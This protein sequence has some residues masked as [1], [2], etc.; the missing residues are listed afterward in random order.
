MPR[1]PVFFR[2]VSRLFFGIWPD[3]G[4]VG[5]ASWWP[6]GGNVRSAIAVVARL[7][8]VCFVE[9]GGH[10]AM[11]LALAGG[12]ALDG[13]AGKARPVVLE[14][15]AVGHVRGRAA[16]HVAS[17]RA[18]RIAGAPAVLALVLSTLLAEPPVAERVVAAGAQAARDVAQAHRER[19][20]FLPAAPELGRAERV[21][22]GV[23]ADLLVRVAADARLLARLPA[24]VPAASVVRRALV[25]AV[26]LQAVQR[27]DARIVGGAHAAFAGGP[28]I[29]VRVDA[30]LVDVPGLV[31]AGLVRVAEVPTA[32]LQR[33]GLR[34]R[35][36]RLILD[37]R[38]VARAHARPDLGRALLDAAALRLLA[39]GVGRV[40]RVEAVDRLTHALADRRQLRLTAAGVDPA[41]REIDAGLAAGVALVLGVRE[42]L[43]RIGRRCFLGRRVRHRDVGSTARD[44]TG[45]GQDQSSRQAHVLSK[46]VS[47]SRDLGHPA[48]CQINPGNDRSRM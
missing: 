36:D 13:A 4:R 10:L 37:E 5:L 7:A 45:C 28:R 12:A 3:A 8:G 48:P 34:R 44:G 47:S 43:D 31:V 19:G 33:E 6:C 11:S 27:R 38:G 25:A 16:A 40:G 46:H 1:L 32:L 29:L 41:R 35:A 39:R 24:R 2:V 42:H 9:A 14:A 17:L 15:L 30:C 22:A 23:E 21:A 20:A 18:E 26:R